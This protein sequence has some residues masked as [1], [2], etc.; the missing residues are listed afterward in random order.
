MRLAGERDGRDVWDEAWAVS[1]VKVDG[2][3]FADTGKGVWM[4]V[5]SVPASWL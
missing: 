4:V 5:S 2:H 1:S 3:A